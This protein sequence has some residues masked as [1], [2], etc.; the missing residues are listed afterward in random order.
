MP[1]QSGLK[2]IMLITLT[3]Q[4]W[5]GNVLPGKRQS[6]GEPECVD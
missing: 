3:K 4:E 2:N 6:L 5:V 1:S